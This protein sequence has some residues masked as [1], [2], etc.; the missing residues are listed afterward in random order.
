MKKIYNSKKICVIVIALLSVL[1][2]LFFVGCTS[3]QIEVKQVDGI[4]ASL[5]DR[6][7]EY[8]QTLSG[9]ALQ[10]R[11][12]GTQ[13]ELDAAK[14]I[15]GLMI[16]WGYESEYSTEEGLG[17][18]Q[19]KT[20]FKRLSGEEVKD[21]LAHNVIFSKKSG[22]EK[23]KGEIIFACG[24]DNLYSE[25]ADVSGNLWNADGSY[26]SGSSVA[27]MLTLAEALKDKVC[28]YDLTFA[29]F[30]GSCY[31]WKGA[32]NYVDNLD[33]AQLDKIALVVNF[34]MLG[35]GDNW[36]IY[37]G[38]SK[39]TYG[40]YLNACGGNYVTAV[41]KDRNIGQFALS[42]DAIYN[43]AHIGMLSNQYFFDVKQVPTA[44]FLSLN[45]EINDNPL[46]SEMKGKDNVYHT[47][48]DTLKNMVERKGEE[49]I[50]AQLFE[51]VKT[52]LTAL[53]DSNAETFETVLDVAKSELPD[54]GT[55]S[56][57]SATLAN[58][59]IKI[60]LIA[61][62]IAISFAIRANLTKNF[63][64]YVKAKKAKEG[65]NVDVKEEPKP[66]EDAPVDAANTQEP[67]KTPKKSENNQEDDPFM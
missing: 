37:S 48:N 17:L 35:G 7:Y 3:K 49:N 40:S 20:T 29:F 45:W 57:N 62:L 33:R 19:F 9:E 36:Y 14:Y 64:K 1:V 15:A 54:G 53:D 43:Y 42:E 26:E 58:I 61:I 65:E 60:V 44:N 38:E 55:Q 52:A 66:F 2:T 10:N 6:A 11:T 56:G 50:K 28:D 23:S 32:R 67:P 12:V 31:G 34:A 27:V 51:V 24:Y 13:G 18:Q 22:A 4:D 59:I 8:L 39:N 25:K 5:G 46:F 63:D 47:R 41:P 21:A 30:S 16:D